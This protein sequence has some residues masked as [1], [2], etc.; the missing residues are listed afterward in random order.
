[1]FMDGSG[2][3]VRETALVAG[4]KKHEVRSI[5]IAL[6]SAI[7]DQF[8]LR[9]MFTMLRR[10]RGI[11]LG[12]TA[13]LTALAIIILFLLT[14]RYTASTALLLDTRKTQVIDMQQVMSGL[15]PEAAALRSEMDVLRSRAL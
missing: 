5:N 4:A 15:T 7:R 12:T 6:P 9:E 8:D 1:M 13:V 3:G 2:A 10:R 11:I 14:P